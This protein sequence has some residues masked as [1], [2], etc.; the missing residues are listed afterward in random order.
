M[1]RF[2]FSWIS[3]E[4]FL[5][6]FYRSSRFFLIFHFF[7][8]PPRYLGSAMKTLTWNSR[9]GEHVPFKATLSKILNHVVQYPSS[10]RRINSF[11][12][13]IVPWIIAD[14]AWCTLYREMHWCD[15]VAWLVEWE[16]WCVERAGSQWKFIQ[17]L[18]ATLCAPGMVVVCR[19]AAVLSHHRA[20]S[21][22]YPFV[23]FFFFFNPGSG[24]RDNRTKETRLLSA[25]VRHFEPRGWTGILTAELHDC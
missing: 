24:S 19:N 9:A 8:L 2:S 1:E 7:Q 23:I 21:S 11:E 14:H 15:V 22:T 6:S 3:K 18:R 13:S 20:P 4:R 25:V 10:C 17:P 5:A 12:V 16:R